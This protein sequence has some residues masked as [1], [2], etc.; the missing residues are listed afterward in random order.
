M[1]ASQPG[2]IPLSR[3]R[4]L[5]YRQSE[6]DESKA[7]QPT[8]IAYIDAHLENLIQPDVQLALLHSLQNRILLSENNR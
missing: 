6:Y 4:M 1:M 8:A 2:A 7:P 3:N 5:P